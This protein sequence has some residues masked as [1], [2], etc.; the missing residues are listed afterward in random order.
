MGV[1]RIQPSNT[2]A[3]WRWSLVGF[4]FGG[5]IAAFTTGDFRWLALSVVPGLV[6]AK[7]WRIT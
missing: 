3:I 5:I 7:W 2:I 1:S 6:F 4:F